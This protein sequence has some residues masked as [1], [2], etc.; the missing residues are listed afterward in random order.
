MTRRTWFV[1]LLALA[2]AV[3][4]GFAWAGGE[5][6]KQP[7]PLKVLKKMSRNLASTRGYKVN[8]EIRGGVSKAPDHQISEQSVGLNYA[9]QMYGN[10]MR[11][12]KMNAYRSPNNKGAIRSGGMWYRLA[13]VPDG[14]KLDRLFP[15]PNKVLSAALKNPKRI[16]W[17]EDKTPEEIVVEGD[18]HT[19]V[20]KK[21]YGGHPT[22]LLVEIPDKVAL[23][24]FVDVENS[25]AVSGG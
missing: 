22:R 20:V 19:G 24:Y 8:C 13:S 21:K 18:G 3:P 11:V 15:F 10:I 12:P 17:L 14:R 25:G 16:Q 4:F 1:G 6:E 9:A 7:N 23:Q 2:L 5:M